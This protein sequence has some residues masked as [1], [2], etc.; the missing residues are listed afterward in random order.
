MNLEISSKQELDNRIADLE[1][2]LQQLKMQLNHLEEDEQH[3]AIE[4]LEMYLEQIDNK[5]DNLR[6]FWS[7]VVHEFQELFKQSQNEDRTGC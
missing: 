4:N 3:E 5:Y 2:S 6:S 1:E 7:V